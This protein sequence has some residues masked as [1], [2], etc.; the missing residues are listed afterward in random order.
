MRG[1]VECSVKSGLE[2]EGLSG[3]G[4]E[5]EAEGWAPWLLSVM[6]GGT[7]ALISAIACVCRHDRQTSNEQQRGRERT[8]SDWHLG[9]A[10]IS[11]EWSVYRPS[12]HSSGWLRYARRTSGAAR[13]RVS[14]SRFTVARRL[15]LFLLEA[16]LNQ[17]LG[18][19]QT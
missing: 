17:L 4:G 15:V 13:R 9:R 8:G 1:L 10:W 12:P 19:L 6:E 18:S 16:S 2:E 11:A 7:G 14:G 5:D 3:E